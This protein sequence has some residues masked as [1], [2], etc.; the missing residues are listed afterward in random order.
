MPKE[1]K[2]RLKTGLDG[3]TVVVTGGNANIGRAIA[4]AFAAE[5]AQVAIVGRDAA[6][7][8][9]VRDLLVSRGAADVS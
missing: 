3:R 5:G 1:R 8:E 7:G 2:N 9:K 4:L 6:Q